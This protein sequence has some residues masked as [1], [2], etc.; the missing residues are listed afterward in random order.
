M[1]GAL[2]DPAAETA[3]R[4][5]LLTNAM[6]ILWYVV[7]C[8][9]FR[10]WFSLRKISVSTCGFFLLF[11]WH[12]LAAPTKVIDGEQGL[13]WMVMTEGCVFPSIFDLHTCK[14]SAVQEM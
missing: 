1:L 11:L 6:L 14:F 3:G 5:H 12:M 4:Y 9:K 10:R 13:V 8:M 2:K 7:M